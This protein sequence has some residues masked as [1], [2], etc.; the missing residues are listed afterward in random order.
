MSRKK[1]I[2]TTLILTTLLTIFGIFTAEHYTSRPSFCGSCHIMHKP[3]NSWDKSAHRTVACVDCHYAP[4]EQHSIKAKF[5]GLSQSFSYFASGDHEVRRKAWIEDASCTTS[6]CHPN[7]EKQEKKIKYTEKVVYIHKTHFD[8]KIEGQSIHCNTCHLHVSSDKHF[9]VPMT[10]CFLCHFKNTEFNKGR[11]KCSLCHEIPTKSLQAQKD[12]SKPDEKPITHKSLE[13]AKVPCRSCHYELVQGNGEIKEEGCLNCHDTT[14][15]LEKFSDMKL[16]HQEHVTNHNANC[17][18]CHRPIQHKKIEFLD[19]VRESCTVCHPDHHYYQ[20]LLIVG[21]KR[22]NITS[23]PALM[24]N[25]KTNCIGCHL[26]EVIKDGEKVMHGDAKACASCH[27]DKHELMMQDWKDKAIEEIKN[28][29]EIE[30]DLVVLIEKAKT[31]SPGENLE[32]AIKMMEE[33]RENLYIVE[34]G[35]GVHNQKYSIQ[36]LDAA[37]NNYE[38]AIDLLSE[39]EDDEEVDI[40]CECVDGKLKCVDEEAEAEAA[41]NDCECDENDELVCE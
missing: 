9:E 34:N 17:F 20:K 35:G 30:K 39:D 31:G 5:K 4:G 36:L 37:M 33:G 8:K 38:D 11:A 10:A 32:Q 2:L 12:A 29:R 26:K 28:A 40:D 1:F 6:K 7:Q 3:F 41:D 21:D 22:K 23:I 15:E 27:T 24:Y 13:E 18:D 16:M 19:P 25:V 14:E